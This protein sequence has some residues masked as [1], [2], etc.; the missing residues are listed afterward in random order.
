MGWFVSDPIDIF[1]D[2]LRSLHYNKLKNMKEEDIETIIS[3]MNKT[4][5]PAKDYFNLIFEKKTC[6]QEEDI[7]ETCNYLLMFLSAPL[8]FEFWD[9]MRDFELKTECDIQTALI[10]LLKDSQLPVGNIGNELLVKIQKQRKVVIVNKGDLQKFDLK[11]NSL[12][13]ELSGKPLAT[14]S[15]KPKTVGGTRKKRKSMRKNR[16]R[17]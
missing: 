5:G 7:K 15:K 16:T 2:A 12:N 13:V 9:V 1:K 6:E 8:A 11:F 10:P 3:N 17:K 4:G 14:M